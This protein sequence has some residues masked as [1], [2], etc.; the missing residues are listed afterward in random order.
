MDPN[1]PI[2]DPIKELRRDL[3]KFWYGLPLPIRIVSAAIVYVL[4]VGALI[5]FLSEHGIL[6]DSNPLLFLCISFT[7]LA[8][9]IWL[10]AIFVRWTVLGK[11]R[12]P[13]K[14]V[15]KDDQP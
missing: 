6:D 12:S 13:S 3:S 7:I 11:D 1:R 14:K 2:N 9:A 5:D 10:I 8:P 15:N 4:L